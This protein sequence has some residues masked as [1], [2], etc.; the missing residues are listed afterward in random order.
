M[1]ESLAWAWASRVWPKTPDKELDGVKFI[2]VRS[3]SLLQVRPAMC[4]ICERTRTRV[5]C[6]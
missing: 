5:N 2:P 1:L 4:K 3:M 6:K